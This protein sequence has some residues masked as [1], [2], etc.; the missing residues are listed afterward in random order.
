MEKKIIITII[1][2]NNYGRNFLTRLN[3]NALSFSPVIGL[4]GHAQKSITINWI[5]V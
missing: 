1:L 4:Q 3:V 5:H 2:F